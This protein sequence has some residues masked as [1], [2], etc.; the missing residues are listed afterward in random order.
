M[1]H[2]MAFGLRIVL[3]TLAL[4]RKF[5]RDCTRKEEISNITGSFF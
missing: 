4:Y 3:R 1:F 2:V 5:L